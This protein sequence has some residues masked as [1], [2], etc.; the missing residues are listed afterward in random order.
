MVKTIDLFCGAGL[1][2]HAFGERGFDIALA[3]DA[4]ADATKSYNT[5]AVNA[6]AQQGDVGDISSEISCDVILAGPPCQ[7]FSTLGKRCF[8]DARNKLSL[9]LAGWAESTSAKVMVIENVPQFAES[10]QYKELTRRLKKMGFSRITWVLDAVNHGVAQHR[11]RSITIYSKIGMPKIP[12]ESHST[13]TVRDA[14]KG[15]NTAGDPE[16]LH[17]INRPTPLA[18]HRMQH[19]PKG[20]SKI[21]LMSNMP[22]LCP[23][24]WFALGRQATDV[25]GRLDYEYPAN[26][27]RCAFLNPSK[28]RYIH[29]T[30][31]RAITLREGARLQGIPDHWEFTGSRSSV[32]KQIGNGVPF[33]LGKDLA[34]VVAELF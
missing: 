28:G 32:A 12:I 30:E 21:D 34:G 17:K 26:T 25:W 19:I 16:G 1:L 22:H 24:S 31:N 18:L 9:L 6:V 29:P 15:L 11:K 23:E 3:I 10:P 27:L 7:G 2:G 14:F 5:N 33:P 13:L 4:N 20:G 8:S